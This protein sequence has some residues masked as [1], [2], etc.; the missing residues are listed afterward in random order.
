A[1]YGEDWEGFKELVSKS[2]IKDKDLILQ[3]LSMY[4]TS[5]QREDEIKNM[6]S[7]FNELKKDI[8]P[9][10]RRSVIVNTIDLEG[11]TDTEMMALVEAGKLDQLNLN[12][13][14]FVAESI[15]QDN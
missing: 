13:L 9:Q 10:L 3:V 8:L 2:N 6:S 15:A 5:T 14:L 1:A 7:V 11:K 4:S 12:E